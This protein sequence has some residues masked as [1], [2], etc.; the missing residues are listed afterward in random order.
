MGLVFADGEVDCLEDFRKFVD[1]WRIDD[2]PDVWSRALIANVRVD[3]EWSSSASAPKISIRFRRNNKKQIT[4]N[5]FGWC[6]CVYVP[7]KTGI[8]FE[9]R[10]EQRESQNVSREEH[11]PKIYNKATKHDD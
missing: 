4:L 8:V 10:P 9:V 6:V 3:L 7:T 1:C 5:W 11:D 2:E